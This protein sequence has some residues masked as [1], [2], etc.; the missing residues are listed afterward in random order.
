M[1]ARDDARLWPKIKVHPLGCWTW[2]GTINHAG[3]GTFKMKGK[4][5]LAHRLLY[6]LEVG[7]IPE[8]LEIDHLCFTRCCCNPAHLEPV[9][10]AENVR[11]MW[12]APW[13][14]PNK[15][16]REKTH[17]K[18]GHPR[19][20]ENTYIQNAAG[21]KRCV[22]CARESTLRSYHRRKALRNG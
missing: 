8:G 5:H 20:P 3:Y 6:E 1:D 7:P 11:R 19:T 9:T 16:Q 14:D 2:Q 4:R 15:A 10:H 18:N 21:H 22:I 17:C 12:A 13:T